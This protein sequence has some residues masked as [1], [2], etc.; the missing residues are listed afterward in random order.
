M[1]RK[2]AQSKAPQRQNDDIV[3]QD[4]ATAHFVRTLVANGQA[5]RANADGSLPPGVTHEIV[6]ETSTGLPI[7]RRRRF[8][9][10]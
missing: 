7:L 10:Y 5:A 1:A 9:V 8:A 2:K 6:G 4:E 3:P